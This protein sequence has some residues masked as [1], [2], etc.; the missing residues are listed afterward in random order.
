[1]FNF[2]NEE[3]QLLHLNTTAFTYQKT[4]CLFFKEMIKQ[5]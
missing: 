5:I 3:V 1:M 4:N 2:S